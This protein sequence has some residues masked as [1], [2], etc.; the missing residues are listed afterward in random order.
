[1]TLIFYPQQNILS[2]EWFHKVFVNSVGADATKVEYYRVAVVSLGLLCALL[3]VVIIWMGTKYTAERD[4]QEMNMD[5]LQL[6]TNNLTQERDHFQARNT[7]L[8][9]EKNDVM[10]K[11]NILTAEKEML[12]KASGEYS[13]ITDLC[14][15]DEHLEYTTLQSFYKHVHTFWVSFFKS[16]THKMQNNSYILQ[17]ETQHWKLESHF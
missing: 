16:S 17:H 8:T 14:S 3:L 12:Q 6:T 11:I 9:A 4:Q 10:A 13:T 5:Q 7:N 1:M 15:S 2:D